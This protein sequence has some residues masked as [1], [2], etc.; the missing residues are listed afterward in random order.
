MTIGYVLL[1]AGVG[2]YVRLAI[3]GEGTVLLSF[4]CCMAS[5]LFFNLPPLANRLRGGSDNDEQ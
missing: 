2:I 3:T 5:L 4:A 1:L